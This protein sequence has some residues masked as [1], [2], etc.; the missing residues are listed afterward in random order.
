MVNLPGKFWQADDGH[1]VDVRGLEAPDPMVAILGYIDQSAEVDRVIVHHFREP[2]FIY[3]D[4]A[5][6]GWS[7]EIVPGEPD[8]V[9]LVLTRE[10]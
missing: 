5:E 9:R 6:R 1:H 7:H 2:I 8:E 10:T 4:L 3:P